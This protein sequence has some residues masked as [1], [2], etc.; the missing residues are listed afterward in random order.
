M[1]LWW[2]FFK[3][4][5]ILFYFFSLYKQEK[6][7]LHNAHLINGIKNSFEEKILVEVG[8]SNFDLKLSALNNLFKQSKQAALQQV[9]NK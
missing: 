4:S 6:A 1:L 5:Q 8:K 9:Q 3:D 7:N 2:E